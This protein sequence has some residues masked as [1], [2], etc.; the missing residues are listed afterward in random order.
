MSE[1]ARQAEEARLLKE[2]EDDRKKAEEYVKLK[3]ET[4][5]ITAEKLS[6]P[7]SPQSK[8][9]MSPLSKKS[10]EPVSKNSYEP[11]SPKP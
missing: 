9:P 2:A 3:K 1:R 10:N 8:E 11:L 5:P 4:L 6:E 7:M